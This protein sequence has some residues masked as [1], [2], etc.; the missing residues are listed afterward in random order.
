MSVLVR[1]ALWLPQDFDALAASPIYEDFGLE[2]HSDGMDPQ[3][4]VGDHIGE[5]EWEMK[6]A[7]GE[8]Q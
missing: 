8:R 3:V 1:P 7:E 4:L 2:K 6:W 5:A